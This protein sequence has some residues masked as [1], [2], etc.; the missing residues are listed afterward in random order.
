[1]KE[2]PATIIIPLKRQRDNWLHQCVVSAIEQ[3]VFCQIRVIIHETT[4]ES[5]LR[6]LEGLAGQNQ[7]VTI[8]KRSKNGF[9][10]GLNQGWR[11]SDSKRIGFL[12]SDD[13]L[14]PD[15]VEKCLEKDTDIVSTGMIY[16]DEF[17]L[18]FLEN[19]LDQ[20]TFDLLPDFEQKAA[21]LKHFYMFKKSKLKEVGGLDESLATTGVDDYDLI[22]TL[23][24][25]GAT[26]TLLSSP[27]YHYRDHDE[28]RLTLQSRNVQIE[29]LLQIFAKHGLSEERK[30]QLVTEKSI[31]LGQ[32]VKQA[33]RQMEYKSKVW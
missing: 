10:A 13:W 28:E 6:V 5:N 3:S 12:L 21:Y 9:A 29:N 17:G 4:P 11:G 33:L 24:E 25:N 30:E 27:L 19:R 14:E 15:A 31:W 7:N 26:T 1:M 2:Y 18:I 8:E 20:K 22:W 23:L 32:T 16:H